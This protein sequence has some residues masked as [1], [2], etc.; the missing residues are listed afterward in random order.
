[1]KPFFHSSRRIALVLSAVLLE[2]TVACISM[3]MVNGVFIGAWGWPDRIDVLTL[4]IL[5]GLIDIANNEF[6]MQK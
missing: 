6:R 4:L 2:V 3:L 5:M 1:M